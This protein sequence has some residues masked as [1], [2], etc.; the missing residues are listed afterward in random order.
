MAKSMFILNGESDQIGVEYKCGMFPKIPD[1]H[2]KDSWFLLTDGIMDDIIVNERTTVKEIRR[3]QYR[4]LVEISRNTLVFSHTFDSSCQEISYTFKV[5]VKANVY[6]SDPI[7]FYANIRNISVRDFLNNQFSLDVKGVTRKYSILNYNG[8]DE[9]LTRILTTTTILDETS[10][11]SYRIA[12]VMTEPNE[13]A[14]RKLKELE[15]MKINHTISEE[16][17]EISEAD[18][19]STY[20]TVIWEEVAKGKISKIDAIE[21]I[22]K[23]KSENIDKKL[24]TLIKF[25][26]HGAIGDADMS[27]YS[28]KLLSDSSNQTENNIHLENEDKNMRAIDELFE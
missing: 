6:V 14:K 19:N 25:R 26:K 24:D 1:Y 2:K 4:R 15:D 21:K 5:T 9:D 7:K 12:T 18:M 11:L 16:A 28:G 13:E 20:E 8:I 22:D 3:G 17:K 10:G 27:E 23:Y